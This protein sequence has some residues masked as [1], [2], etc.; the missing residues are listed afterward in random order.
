MKIFLLLLL[1]GLVH[2]LTAQDEAL[3]VHDDW[4]LKKDKDGVRVYT[5]WIEATDVRKARQMKVEMVVESSIENILMVLKDDVN[6]K[7]WAYR[8]KEFYNFDIIDENNWYSYSELS[9]PWPFQNKDLITKNHLVRIPSENQVRVDITGVADYLPEKKS[10]SRIP[11]FE[12]GWTL[13]RTGD[14]AVK[15]EY[16]VFTK[17]EPVL[18]RWI[19]D[20]IVEQGA[21]E[22]L[23]NFRELLE[24]HSNTLAKSGKR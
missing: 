21:W 2:S 18:P 15:I 17:S 12:G 8:A 6:A 11:H 7:K 13:T 4:R 19:I 23:N 24:I 20:P 9:I 16:L 5:R 1:T 22:T 3:E 14:D 10:L